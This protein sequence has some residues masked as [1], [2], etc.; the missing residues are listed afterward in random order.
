MSQLSGFTKKLPPIISYIVAAL[1]LVASGLYSYLLFHT[2]VELFSI[3]AAFV[4][5]ILAWNTRRVQDNHYLLLIGIASLFSGILNI[6]HTLTYK[7]MGV[8]ASYGADLTTQLWIA[9]R[10]VL[11]LSF[12]IA[13][14]FLQ[15]KLHPLKTVAVYFAVTSS[16]LVAIFMRWFPTCYIE[17]TGLTQFKIYSEYIISLIFLVSLGLIIKN[18]HAFD[19]DVRRPVILSLLCATA[20]ELAFSNYGGVYGIV[21]MVGHY[22]EFL[23]YYFLYRAIAV[24]GLVKPTDLLFR[25]LKLSEDAL[26]ESEARYR[27]LFENMNNGFAYH[28][29]IADEE[30]K[31][32]DYIFL[33]VNRAFEKLTNLK[34]ERIIGKRV[35]E[36]I[37]GIENDPADWIGSY[38]KVALTGTDARFEQFAEQI[39]KWY[40]IIA[41]SPMKG[42]F[43]TVFEDITERKKS[44]SD[45]HRINLRLNLLSETAKELLT[46]D[47]PQ[48]IVQSLCTKIMEYLGCDVFFNYLADNNIRRLHLNA[49][50]G[51][52]EET[53]RQI[54]W[55]DYGV[56]VC[57]CAARDGC[58]IVAENIPGTKDP[59]TDLVRSFGI[60]AYACHPFL[61]R[62]RVIGTLSFGTRTRLTFSDD[63]LALMKTVSEQVAIA[64]ERIGIL[65]REKRRAEELDKRVQERTAELQGAVNA[66]QGE[67]GERLAAEQSLREA[68]EKLEN[69]LE[70][71]GDGFFTLDRTWRYT[72]L[73]S[74]AGL[75]FGRPSERLLGKVI[76]EEFPE[77]VGSAYYQNYHRAME[78]GAVIHFDEYYIPLDKWYEGTIY[79]FQDG[80]SV[81][82]HDVTDRKKAEESS[83]ESEERYHSIFNQ[84]LDGILLT[85]PDGTILA[86]NSAACR[87]LGR[88][89][90]E[91][92][93]AGRSGIVN[94]TDPKTAAFFEE[95]TRTG[96]ARGEITLPSR[97]GTTFPVELSSVLF[98]DRDGK[99]LSSMIV[100]DITE[101]KMAEEKLK[102]ANA[103]NRTLLEASLDP[104][105]TIDADGKITDVNV[106][107]EVVTGYARTELVGTDFPRY[108]TEAEKAEKG[109]LQAFRDGT[110][111][112]YGLE[113]RHRDGHVTPVLYNATVYRDDAGKVLG[114]F[115]AARDITER[116]EAERRM[117]V[118]TD[119]LKLYTRKFSRKE[120]LDVVVEEIRAWSGCRHVGVRISDPNGDISYESCGG[121]NS[122]FLDSERVLSLQRD[123]CV[124]TRVIAGIP[125]THELAVRTP[126]G[127]FYCNNMKKFVDGLTTEEKRQYRGV[128]M[129]HG[130]L[131]LAVVPIRHRD[132]IVG[133]IHITDESEGMVPRKNVE[134]I[135]QLAFIIGE[136]IIRFGM[137]G[138][139]R[140]LNRE[141]EQRVAERTAQLE[142]ANRE[143]EAFAYSVSH[144]LRAP[145]RSI[146]GFSHAL[147]EDYASAIDDAGKEYL[148]RVRAAATKMGQ[149]IDALLNL[150][151]LTRG[152]LERTMVDLS[153]LAKAA[154][155]DMRKSE[156]D[157]AAQFF[158]ADGMVVEGDPLMLRVVIE[159]LF[160]NAWKFTG[161]CDA[162][163]IEFGVMPGGQNP[164]YFIRDNGTGFDMTYS[165][166]LF[167][168]FQRLHSSEEFPGLGIGLATVQRI[169][170]RH[171]GRIW[172]EGERGKGATFYFTMR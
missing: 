17:S 152:E 156:P 57:G 78:T 130:F 141:L 114:V 73:N 27:A 67:I 74:K 3:T 51:I 105:V 69:T 123:R 157:R 22:F 8:F 169:I 44:E 93:A 10:Y 135:E 80:I 61:S 55:L 95:L 16:L 110:V 133:A 56:A 122:A 49:Y 131:S 163:L 116:R 172:A 148:R 41:Y 54:E 35:T 162:A 18:R 112:D 33:E 102:L 109:Y 6:F 14:F 65:D 19:A 94:M 88:T 24:T 166:K 28:Q 107:T 100:R 40:S 13:T 167:S 111:K 76:W 99:I 147:L 153:S 154:S 45:L 72:Y 150:S 120:Y 4:V 71:I 84:S 83:R 136:A 58:R 121:F 21:N 85:S 96:K 39:G 47:R 50:A 64:M 124:C 66:L 113:I 63:D 15:K 89:E 38:G 52:P 36:A 59:R 12:L 125:E 86:S 117:A 146:N 118:T 128:C 126:N 7:G 119:L 26:K 91:I 29:I 144:D 46:T 82:F 87:I 108:F 20:S 164:V 42:R 171:G 48:E 129:R 149:L 142:A 30:G 161:K 143:L 170:H 25:N 5:F 101:R 151:R 138:E 79:P 103:Y 134:F 168:A 53:A 104:L 34:R 127:S 145:L 98:K 2:L 32:I 106:A 62:G 165:G 115:A 68:S 158:V 77:A 81:F 92:R 139:L 160:S 60:A 9:F 1:A 31:P 132:A 140:R 43:V 97:D 155:D 75:M 70:S 11:G 23:S 37:P 137:E 90:K 159:N